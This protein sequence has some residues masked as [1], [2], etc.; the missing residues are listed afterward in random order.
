MGSNPTADMHAASIS[1]NLHTCVHATGM[2]GEFF[3]HSNI[4]R[5]S[6]LARSKARQPI[7]FFSRPL[8]LAQRKTVTNESLS[9]V[10]QR[11]WSSYIQVSIKKGLRTNTEVDVM[12]TSKCNTKTKETRRQPRIYLNGLVEMSKDIE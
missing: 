8:T 5:N 7:L 3:V 12:S 4:H 6:S 1:Q 10:T 9:I 11:V 2:H